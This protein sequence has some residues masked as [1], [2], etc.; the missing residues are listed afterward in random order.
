[1]IKK[2]IVIAS[3]YAVAL[4]ALLTWTSASAEG[5]FG[6]G[7]GSSEMKDASA[8]LIG[9]RF[10]DRDKTFRVFG[11]FQF[12][13]NAALELGYVDFGEFTGKVGNTV[14]D[15]WEASAFDLS[16]VGKLP[17]GN[18]SLQGKVGLAFW[19]VDDA[20]VGNSASE[21]GTD[22]TYGVGLQYDF[23]KAFGLRVDWQKYMDVGD[24]DATGQSDLTTLSASA[25]FKF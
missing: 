11:G 20:F 4:L 22:L 7:Y 24:K 16:L 18:F 8:A 5:Y 25:V 19:K 9:T 3:G 17:F 21:S 12:N 23:T 6:V 10:D 14:T 1:M 15:R 2:R 13:P